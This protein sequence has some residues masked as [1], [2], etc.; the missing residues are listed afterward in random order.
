M[1]LTI[2]ELKEVIHLMPDDFLVTVND[3][4]YYSVPGIEVDENL[5]EFYTHAE[6]GSFNCP[7]CGEVKDIYRNGEDRCLGVKIKTVGRD[8]YIGKIIKG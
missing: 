8:I 5:W 3:L 1:K 4:T 2:A 6:E 7:G